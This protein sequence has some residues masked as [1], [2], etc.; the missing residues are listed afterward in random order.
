MSKIKQPRIPIEAIADQFNW[1]LTRED[2]DSEHIGRTV[3]WIEWEEGRYKA[4]YDEPAIGRSCILDIH[5]W[6]F[7]WQTTEVTEILEHTDEKCKFRTK[8]SIYV[9]EKI[10][11]ENP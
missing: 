4:H 11:W 6:A 3:H 5:P 7:T 10:D 8:N 9:L 2:D 1:K